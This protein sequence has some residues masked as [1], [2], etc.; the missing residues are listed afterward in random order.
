MEMRGVA[1]RSFCSTW[2]STPLGACSKSSVLRCDWP[3][4]W[5]SALLYLVQCPFSQVPLELR[6]LLLTD[7]EAEIPILWPP[8][9][10]SQLTGKDPDAGKN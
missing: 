7:A 6:E 9:S 3:L 8:D 4:G 2:E 1:I 5:R 10:N